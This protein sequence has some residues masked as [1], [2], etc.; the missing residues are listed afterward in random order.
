MEESARV[1]R[2]EKRVA[3][4]WLV[5]MREAKTEALREAAVVMARTH[6]SRMDRKRALVRSLEL[7]LDDAE[8]QQRRAAASHVARVDALLTLHERGARK[9]SDAFAT[10]TRAIADA[11]SAEEAAIEARHARHRRA[12]LDV[13]DAMEKAHASSFA[14]R[15]ARFETAREALRSRDAEAFENAKARLEASVRACARMCEDAHE[16]YVT[17]TDARAA[18]FEQRTARD[19]RS[20]RWIDSRARELGRLAKRA[21]AARGKLERQSG[22]WR[23]KNEA[24]REEKARVRDRALAL[25]ATTKRFRAE[26]E[27][28]LKALLRD[29]NGA[30]KALDAKLIDAERV[31]RLAAAARRLET[32]R[33]RVVPFGDEAEEAGLETE[34]LRVGG[35]GADSDR[36]DSATVRDASEDDARSAGAADALGGAVDET[37]VLERFFRRHNRAYLDALAAR[38]ELER[39][40]AENTDLRETVAARES[41]DARGGW[42]SG[43]AR[44]RSA[45]AAPPTEGLVDAG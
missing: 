32:E 1:A 5:I 43:R 27:S 26:A 25:A 40:C 45:E 12:M 24:L 31:L 2:N 39:L 36:S 33:E 14:I 4:R 22:E 35:G 44:E 34:K 19:S 15:R 41:C 6:A 37:R 30:L 23:A 20:A 21:R 3:A 17:D 29:S 28:K 7:E 13:L 10:E 8:T 38:R 42:G 9:T 11:F 16:A 18:S